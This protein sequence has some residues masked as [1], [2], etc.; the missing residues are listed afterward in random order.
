MLPLRSLLT[1]AT[2][3][4]AGALGAQSA[5]AIVVGTARPAPG[6]RAYGTIDIAAGPDSAT[7]I[8][9]VVVRGAKPGPVVAFVSGAH[10]TEYT[11]IVALTRL[12]ERLDPKTMSGT[13][14]IVPLLNVA[15]FERMVPHVNPVDGKGMNASYPG[16]PA[17]T[18]TSRVLAAINEQVVKPAEVI[19]DLHGGDLDEDLRPYTYWIRGGFRMKDAESQA[20]AL[21]FGLDMVIVRD[22]DIS[23][24]AST[25]NLSG[26]AV[27]QAKTTLVA[28][29]GRSGIV[30]A[31]ETD[32][33]LNGALNVLGSMRVISRKVRPGKVTYVG[34]DLRV[35][36]DGGGM[37]F[38]QVARGARVKKGQL[39]GRIT[40]YV[41]RPQ[42]DVAAPQDGVVTF[43]RG[44]PSMSKGATL[45]TVVKVHG[46]TAPA[47]ERPSR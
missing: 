24:P 21:S 6:E 42:G 46:E 15:S 39:I 26:F 35:R 8:Q 16:D 34:E 10:G 36:A 3:A 18:Q 20:L 33:L 2:V 27:S 37:F 12:A 45:V 28:E 44:V 13:V 4:L 40:D 19:V 41:G 23:D 38:A 5:D 32:L 30:T 14:I 47:F 17:G 7:R 9:V 31:E 29:A 25:R 11:S 22:I 43:I 1:A